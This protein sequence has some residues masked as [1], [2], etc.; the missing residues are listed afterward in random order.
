MKLSQALVRVGALALSLAVP[1]QAYADSPDAE[2]LF[3]EGRALLL[4]GRFA[5]ACAKLEESQLAEARVGTLLN[6]AACHERLG[7]VATAH[8]EYAS[9]LTA[10]NQEGLDT[11]AKLAQERI[12]Q[13]AP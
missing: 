5:E 12:D 10:A 6:L 8:R 13:L 7:L 3:Q 4:E 9:A 1:V 11:R 2:R